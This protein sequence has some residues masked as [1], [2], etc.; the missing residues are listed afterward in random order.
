MQESALPRPADPQR[1][2]WLPALAAA[3]A[4]PLMA[5]RRHRPPI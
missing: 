4:L 1:R 5:M 3:F 2:R